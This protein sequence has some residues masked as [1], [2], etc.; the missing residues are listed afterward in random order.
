MKAVIQW[1]KHEDKVHQDKQWT[2]C[3]VK[4]RGKFYNGPGSEKTMRWQVGQTI[5][6]DL[7]EEEYQKKDGSMASV[8]KFEIMEDDDMLLQRLANVEARLNRCIE[9][10]SKLA[11][12]R[13]DGI[14]ATAPT[15]TIQPPNQYNM[16]E[17]KPAP[18]PAPKKAVAYKKKAAAPAPTEDDD[19]P[20]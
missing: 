9:Y 1:I 20:F 13:G 4:I 12:E 18:A 5:N 11:Q 15:T 19:L 14:Q 17:S 6:V 2:Q 8:G 3:S 7:W 16:P 10:I